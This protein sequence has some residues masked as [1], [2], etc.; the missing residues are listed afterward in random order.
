MDS[1][2]YPQ[3]N[4][5]NSYR[6]PDLWGRHGQGVP[7]LPSRAVPTIHLIKYTLTTQ[8]VI[9]CAKTRHVQTPSQKGLP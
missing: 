5:V 7:S 9:L 4:V 3:Q 2:H 6:T 8:F 1:R